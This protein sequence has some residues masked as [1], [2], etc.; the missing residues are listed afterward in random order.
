MRKTTKT[1]TDK[2]GGKI[3]VDKKTGKTV[4]IIRNAEVKFC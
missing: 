4:F 2:F 1:W 3:K